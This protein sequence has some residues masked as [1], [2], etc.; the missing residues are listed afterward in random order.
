[1]LL[2]ADEDI[3][4]RDKDLPELR[5]LLDPEA[6]VETIQPHVPGFEVES[7]RV[8]YLKY[9]PG[10]NCLA[11]YKMSVG[12]REVDVYAKTFGPDAYV[13]IENAAK[14]KSVP[15]PLGAGRVV[16]EER[17]ISVAFFP[18]DDKLKQIGKLS[19]NGGKVIE[20][21][22]P[23]R[24]ELWGGELRGLRYKPERRYVA[25]I[26]VDGEPRAVVKF[27]REEDYWTTRR[28]ARAFSNAFKTTGPFRVTALIGGSKKHYAVAFE[29][30]SGEP[31]GEAIAD[32]AQ[33]TDAL[34]TAGAALAELHAQPSGELR[35]LTRKAEAE[36]L[37]S[38]VEPLVFNTP[39]LEG[40]I[41]SL[42]RTLSEKLL[43]EAPVWRPIHGDFYEDQVVLGDGTA[44]LLDLDEAASGDPAADLGLFIA[45]LEKEAM[46]GH[47]D[48]SV[49]A[50]AAESLLEGYRSWGPEMDSG[51][52]RF[53]TAVG[54]FRLAPH[55]FRGREPEWPEGTE[56]ILRRAEE[57]LKTAFPISA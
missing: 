27:Y 3:V 5:T 14:R 4:R 20:R 48:R 51:K 13:K 9:K 47:V 23:D 28:N 40:Q 26:S 29:W 34:E 7:A 24:P 16:L 32:P 17:D 46:L 31:L 30:Q 12:G 56:E 33:R 6:F 50:S 45:H 18:N 54:L 52:V 15:D 53:Y 11:A 39:R 44:T 21:L 41:R 38:L 49:A 36:V 10:T 35:R 8:V 37:D 42:A 1:M 43:R 19:E 25:R 55:P 2:R 22:L 57:L